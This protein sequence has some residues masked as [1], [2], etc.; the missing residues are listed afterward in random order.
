MHT[1]IRLH[2]AGD[3]TKGVYRTRLNHRLPGNGGGG[4]RH[5]AP[6]EDSLLAPKWGVKNPQ[7]HWYFGFPSIKQLRHWFYEDDFFRG[8][9]GYVEVSVVKVLGIEEGYTQAIFDIRR[10]RIVRTYSLDAV[11]DWDNREEYT[12]PSDD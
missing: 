6:Y 1:I 12:V 10:P 5:P 3:F 4:E 8:N 2:K 11:L 7:H 9:L